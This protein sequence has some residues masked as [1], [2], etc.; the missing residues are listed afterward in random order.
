MSCQIAAILRERVCDD[1]KAAVTSGIVLWCVRH[2][3]PPTHNTLTLTLNPNSTTAS[4]KHTIPW[5]APNGRDRTII[6]PRIRPSIHASIPPSMHQSIHASLHPS[7]HPCIHP[8]FR[9]SIHPSIHPCMHA[10]MHPSIHPSIDPSIP[11]SLHPSLHPFI[12]PSTHP[13]PHR[14]LALFVYRN[15]GKP[16]ECAQVYREVVAK[17][18][19]H[20][21]RLQKALRDAEGRP[22]GSEKGS[23]GWVFRYAMDAGTCTHTHTHTTTHTQ[24]HTHT[25]RERHTTHT[26]YTHTRARAR[27]THTRTYAVLAS[28]DTAP[29]RVTHSLTHSLTRTQLCSAGVSGHRAIARPDMRRHQRG[30]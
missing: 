1:N 25:E 9:L 17:H 24:P 14:S 15:S 28:A 23:Q 11:P 29:S 27:N 2:S 20:D 10:S 22:T 30:H 13:S 26:L 21:P 12:H 19:P 8:S 7:I 16:A 6:H 5:A 18:A 4:P 3:I